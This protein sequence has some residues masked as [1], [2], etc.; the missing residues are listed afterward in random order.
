MRLTLTTTTSPPSRSGIYHPQQGS[1]QAPLGYPATWVGS[2]GIQ[3]ARCANHVFNLSDVESALLQ[4][5][6]GVQ[7]PVD[8][9]DTHAS[10]R[11][12]AVWRR[13]IRTLAPLWA[14]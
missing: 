5:A 1:I 9:L 14:S 6:L 10:G 3:L 11:R 12:R 7:W 2:I 4:P 8:A 13:T